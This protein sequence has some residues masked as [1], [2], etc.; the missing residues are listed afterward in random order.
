MRIRLPPAGANIM[1]NFPRVNY[2]KAFKIPNFSE[3]DVVKKR[4]HH[5]ILKYHPDRGG[6]EEIAQ[7]IN[8]AYDILSQQKAAYD[9]FLREMLNPRA[10][11]NVEIVF[12]QGFNAGGSSWT[13]TYTTQGWS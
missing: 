8:N 9:A 7:M 4:Y 11:M 1:I 6:K 2:Y 3:P 10:D 13:T 5:L 12:G